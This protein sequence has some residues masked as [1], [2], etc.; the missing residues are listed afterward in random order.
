VGYLLLVFGLFFYSFTQVDLNLTLSRWPP[1]L[2][3]QNFLQQIGYY[4][5]PLSVFFYIVIIF[6]FF[7]FYFL[8]LWLVRIE[9]IRGI[10]G[11]VI[12]TTVILTFS[13]NAFSYDLFNY[14]F[15]AKIVTFYQQ[16]PYLQKALDY[17]SD[18]MVSFMR[19]THRTYPYGPTWLGLTVPL[20]L[21][22]FNVFLPTLYLFKGLMAA[23]F[24]GTVY[25]LKKIL[26]NLKMQSPLYG[27]SLFA[28]NPLVLI[29]SVV[30]AHNDIVMM[31]F[32][33]LSLYL[34]L[35]KRYIFSFTFLAVSIGIKFAT[36]LLLPVFIYI[37]IM[38]IKN[39][40]IDFKRIFMIIFILMCAAVVIASLVSGANK[41]PELQ[42]WYFLMLFPFAALIAQKRI[43]A[44]LTICVSFGM[45]LSYI[46]F[47]LTG[48]WPKDIVDLKIKLLIAA[49][50]VG[51]LV[52]IL[53][54]KRLLSVVKRL[55]ST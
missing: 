23:S 28:L 26:D 43:V 45:L 13:Y 16:N 33:V 41:N 30:S 47:L 24:L 15:D 31:F 12:A 42:P 9:K 40:T 48:E 3:M 44:L 29:E 50:A 53:S 35:R 54:S 18:H 37:A 34:L 6:L 22:G 46:P 4:Q 2:V 21:L 39:K 32:A 51:M 49:I 27:I 20:S 17:P 8:F 7:I 38:Q 36:I 1:M 52:Y 11:L 55:F 10:W 25:F 5:R 19:S 14:I